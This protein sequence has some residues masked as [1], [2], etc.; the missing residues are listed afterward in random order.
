VLV[1][2]DALFVGAVLFVGAA[3]FS[4]DALAISLRS[5]LAPHWSLSPCLPLP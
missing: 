1:V 3:L 5:S 4:V 2:V